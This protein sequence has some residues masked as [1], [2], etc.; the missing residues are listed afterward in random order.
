MR[1]LV[2]VLATVRAKRRGGWF[3]LMGHSSESLSRWSEDSLR[4]RPNGEEL[5]RDLSELNINEGG[6]PV[7]RPAPT[8][9]VIGAFQARFGVVLP[10]GY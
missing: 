1:P 8:E 9:A 4:G 10:E 7:G 2:L 3:V 6:V 5:M